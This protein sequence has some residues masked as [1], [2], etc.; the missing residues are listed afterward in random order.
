MWFSVHSLTMSK[1]NSF[2]NDTTHLTRLWTHVLG[3]INQIQLVRQVMRLFTINSERLPMAW[4]LI[5]L[6]FNATGLY[7][8]FE[9]SLAF[10]CMIV[11]SLCCAFGLALF[12]LQLMEPPR[13]SAATRLSPN[14]ISAGSTAVLP[15]TPNVEN[16]QATERSA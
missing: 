8:G 4:F 6:L 1:I 11:G 3:L 10:G 16:E 7:L 12:V 14:F 13:R 2:V 15:A 9:Y 5:G